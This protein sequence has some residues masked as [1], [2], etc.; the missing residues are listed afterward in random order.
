MVVVGFR[1]YMVVGLSRCSRWL[2]A[3]GNAVEVG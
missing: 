3:V 2:V 1:P